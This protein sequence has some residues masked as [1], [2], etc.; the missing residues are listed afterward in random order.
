[1]RFKLIS[2]S[3][4]YDVDKTYEILNLKKVETIPAFDLVINWF[5]EEKGI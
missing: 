1:M 4:Y 3:W 2:R 5:T